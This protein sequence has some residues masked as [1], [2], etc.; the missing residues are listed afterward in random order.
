MGGGVFSPVLSILMAGESGEIVDNLFIERWGKD[1][2][3]L[4]SIKFMMSR[5]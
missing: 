1:S 2:Y 3:V 5:V 4:W